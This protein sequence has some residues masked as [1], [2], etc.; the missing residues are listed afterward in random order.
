M[1]LYWAGDQELDAPAGSL[2]IVPATVWHDLRNVGDGRLVVVFVKLSRVLG[3]PA[4]P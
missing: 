4:K 1:P 2:V 3:K